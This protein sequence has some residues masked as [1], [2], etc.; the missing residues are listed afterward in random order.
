MTRR[1]CVLLPVAQVAL[2]SGK[3]DGLAEI[4][5]VYVDRLGGGEVAG[6]LRDM[7][8]TAI[9]RSRV[10]AVTEDESRADAVLRGSGEDLVFTDRFSSTDRIQGRVSASTRPAAR[11]NSDVIGRAGSASIG[12]TESVRIEERKHE[13]AA[14][15]RLVNKAGDVVWS[16]TQES[17]GAKFR[18]A[19]ADVAEKI[20]KQL[21]QDLELAR[22]VGSTVE[23]KRTR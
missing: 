15:V 9:Q 7:I 10:F 17:L 4:R 19:S 14:S 23:E 6:H 8:I 20:V 18:G 11:S 22:R 13:A 16:T 5:L 1:L 12:Q 21:R 3:P 2:A